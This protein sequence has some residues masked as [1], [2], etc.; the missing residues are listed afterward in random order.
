MMRVQHTSSLSPQGTAKPRP[1]FTMIELLIVIAIIA[2]LMS[3]LGAAVFKTI[4]ARKARNTQISLNKLYAQL[5]RQMKAVIDDARAEYIPPNVVALAGNEP[6]RARILWI[7]LR[8]KQQF[9]MSYAEAVN[10]GGGYI[11][12]EPAYMKILN[13]KSAANNPAT[14]S[15]ACLLMALTAR[16]RRGV[17]QDA[18]FLSGLEKADTDGDGIPEIVDGY[19]NPVFF[20]R[21]PTPTATGGP[22]DPYVLLT[23]GPSTGWNPN[24]AATFQDPQDPNGT[25]QAP[26]GWTPSNVTGLGYFPIVNM[27]MVPVIVSAGPDGILGLDPPPPGGNGTMTVT[28][29]GAVSDNIYS[30]PTQ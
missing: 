13:G 1:A 17:Q 12:A 11:A 2:V 23:S 30:D 21:W 26:T 10:P 5:Q 15:A 6:N 16:N 22:G 20:Y 24:P 29:S 8:L 4:Q 9:P 14:E 7:K 25:L 27:Y 28:S 19:H 18:D 3:L